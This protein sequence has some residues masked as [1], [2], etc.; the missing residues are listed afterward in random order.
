MRPTTAASLGKSRAAVLSGE[1]RSHSAILTKP[2][3]ERS[4]QT[5]ERLT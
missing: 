4:N 2:A 3:Q 1:Q 5:C